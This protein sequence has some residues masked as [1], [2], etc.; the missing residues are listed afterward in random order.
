MVLT[1]ALARGLPIVATTGGAVPATVDPEAS[2]LVPPGRR[3]GPG[4]GH[5]RRAVAVASRGAGGSGAATPRACCGGWDDA[6]TRFEAAVIELAGTGRTRSHEPGAVSGV[7]APA[8]RAGGSSVARGGDVVGQLAAGWSDRQHV[9][10]VDLGCGA[11]SNLRYLSSRLG[12]DQTWVLVDHDPSSCAGSSVPRSVRTLERVHADLDEY[13]RDLGRDPRPVD[14]VTASAL[15]DLVSDTWL[16][17]FV[18]VCGHRRCPVLAALTYDRTASTGSRGAARRCRRSGTGG[19]V[20][21]TT[22]SGTPSTPIS[23]ATRDW[24]RRSAPRR[25]RV[26]PSSSG[27]GGI[28]SGGRA[29]PRGGSTRRTRTWPRS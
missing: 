15:L 6:V 14:G 23:A 16:E 20:P 19:P 25:G 10:L 27:S 3:A 11:G 29:H 24:G 12:L 13:L 1:E 26:P 22:G 17:R 4:R 18:E 2:V 28:S 9:R 21:R 8:A 7:L 5:R